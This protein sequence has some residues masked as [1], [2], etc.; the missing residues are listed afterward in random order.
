MKD[1]RSFIKTS[2]AVSAGVIL[3]GT[4]NL[5]AGTIPNVAEVN[6]GKKVHI[7]SK[8]LQWLEYPEMAEI[9]RQIGFDGIDLTVRP[10]GHVLP[11]RVSS[12]LPKA[13]QAIRNSG[14]IADRITTA[15]IDPDDPFTLPILETAAKLGVKNYRMGWIEYDQSKTIRENLRMINQKLVKLAAIN[16]KLGLTGAYQNHTGISVGGAVWDLALMLDGI[17]PNY[18]GIRYDIRHATATGGPS[19]P[20]GLKY[21][22][23]KINS[24][25]L[26][27][28]IWEK[29]NGNWQPVSVP[30]GT[31]MVDFKQY[32]KLINELNILGDYTIHFEYDLGGADLGTRN[33]TV[34]PEVVI[35][36]MKRD[37]SIVRNWIYVSL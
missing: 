13:V 7:F 20:I 18:L 22:S 17:N 33:L 29:S 6:R 19:W 12:D 9:A 24:L 31:G 37:L 5:I 30:I 32:F 35:S 25:D 27:D 34:A 23:E 3:A 36:A 28:C 16:Q 14:L 1:R 8:N 15:I 4:H 26:K 2:V 11:E 21:I 10:K